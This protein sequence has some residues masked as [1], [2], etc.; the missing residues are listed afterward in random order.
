MSQSET[1]TRVALEHTRGPHGQ[2]GTYHKEGTSD[3]RGQETSARA[4][5]E[6][7]G[8]SGT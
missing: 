1:V 5:V 4:R 7:Q 3:Q 8:A 2:K 6:G